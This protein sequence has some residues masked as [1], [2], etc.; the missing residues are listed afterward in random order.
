MV[1]AVERGLTTHLGRLRRRLAG[2]AGFAL[3]LALTSVLTLGAMA[4]GVLGYS[5]SNYRQATRSNADVQALALAEAGLNYAYATLYNS[6]APTMDNAVPP[7]TVTL[8][9]G[10]ASYY[11]T[12]E[13]STWRLVG[14]GTVRNPTDSGAPVVRTVSG[15]AS[16]GSASRGTANNAVWN[17]VY[18]DDPDATTNLGNSV[19]VNIPLYVRGDLRISNTAQVS[20]Y[21]LQVG[22]TLEIFNS[23]HVGTAESPVHEAHV[24]GGCRLGASG[25]FTTPCGP[26]QSVHATISDA[27]PTEF[28]KPPV[29]LTGWYYNAKPGPVHGCTVG[30]FPGGFD[31]DTLPNTSRASVDLTP[32]TAYDC[33]VYDTDGTTLLGQ[34]T[35]QPGAPGT[36]TIAGTVYF[37]GPISFSQLNQAVYSGRATIYAAG[38]ITFANQ[39][40]L[41]G[42]AA[43]DASWDPQQ[44]LLAFVSGGDVRVGQQSQFQGAIYAVE[45]YSEDNNSTF[46]GPIIARRVSLANSTTNHY[47]PIGTLMPGMPATYEEV[48]TITNEPGSW[49]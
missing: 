22:G 46:W 10:D 41:C 34:L 16:L 17:Y 23:G 4:A 40:T 20:S 26:A 3:P 1:A 38:D 27:T 18:V 47:V 44:N 37:D 14:V 48:V 2:E 31:N 8:E 6:S 35:W 42:V 19:N 33:R 49:G 30:S 28:T 32:T 43:C 13:G 15:R 11:G 25:P 36:L 5:S 9:T 45:D 39:T 7:R 12:L 21:S 29:D 24:G